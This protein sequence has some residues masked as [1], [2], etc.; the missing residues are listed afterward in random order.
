MKLKDSQYF[1]RSGTRRERLQQCCRPHHRLPWCQHGTGAGQAATCATRG[2]QDVLDPRLFAAFRCRARTRPRRPRWSTRSRPHSTA[3]GRNFTSSH[4]PRRL[5]RGP[6]NGNWDG[7]VEQA[8]A[9]NMA[10]N[11]PTRW[12]TSARLQLRCR[13]AAI[14]ILGAACPAE[15]VSPANSYPG[16]TRR[17]VTGVLPGEPANNHDYSSGYRNY[18]RVINTDDNQGE[19]I[20]RVGAVARSFEKAYARR[21]A[22]PT[23]RASAAPG[24]STSPRSAARSSAPMAARSRTWSTRPTT[25]RWRRRSRRPVRTLPSSSAQSPKRDRKALKDISPFNPSITMFWP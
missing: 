18:S 22:R 19:D 2:I 24:R 1:R 17:A 12:S 14:P 6:S 10:A 3:E 8:N 5:V 16:L 7:A 4:Q 25:N 9:E 21:M 23:G 13:R 20:V 15:T 11:D